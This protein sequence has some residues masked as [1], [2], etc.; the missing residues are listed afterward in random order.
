[1]VR[2]CPFCHEEFDTV[3]AVVSH[4]EGQLCAIERELAPQQLVHL[5]TELVQ[6]EINLQVSDAIES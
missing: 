6:I 4:I 2:R 3:A 5:Q 1:M